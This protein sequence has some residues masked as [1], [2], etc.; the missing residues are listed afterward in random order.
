MAGTKSTVTGKDF[1]GP[2]DAQEMA[3]RYTKE[4]AMDIVTS[5]NVVYTEEVGYVTETEAKERGLKEKKLSGTEFRRLLRSGATI[6]EWFAYP[7]V[8]EILRS[9]EGKA[10]K[11]TAAV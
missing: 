8:V 9:E 11:A 7:K 1:Y 5:E 4:L 6:P 3:R 10:K 2:Y